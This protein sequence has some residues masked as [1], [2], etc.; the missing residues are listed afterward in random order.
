VISWLGK[1]FKK[2]NGD[3]GLDEEEWL[4]CDKPKQIQMPNIIFGD[5]LFVHYAF[6]TQRQYLDNTNILETYKKISI[7]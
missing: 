6:F 1:E 2:F 7:T 5:S 3:V 4:S